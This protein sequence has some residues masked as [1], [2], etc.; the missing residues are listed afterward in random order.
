MYVNQVTDSMFLRPTSEIEVH[1]IVKS[2]PWSKA[3][4]HDEVSASVLKSVVMN[5]VKPL[6]HIFDLSFSLGQFPNKLKLAK[7]VLIFKNDDKVLVC[8]Y[9]PMSVLSVFSKVLE[10]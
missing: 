8:H 9:R 7:V 2:L 5:I 6:T 3:P 1:N 4:G 10:K